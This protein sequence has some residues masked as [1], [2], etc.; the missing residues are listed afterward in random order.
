[1]NSLPYPMGRCDS[2]KWIGILLATLILLQLSYYTFHVL[3]SHLP[4][5]HIEN[6]SHPENEKAADSCDLCDKFLGQSVYFWTQLS[7]LLSLLV[8]LIITDT[9]KQLSKPALRA[10]YP[11]RG[12]PNPSS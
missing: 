1:M 11:L 9:G 7:V 12:P 2:K 8:Y 4:D 6:A 5:S 3:T 10:T